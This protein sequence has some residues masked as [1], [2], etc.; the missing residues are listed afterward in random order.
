MPL[1]KIV[2]LAVAVLLLSLAGVQAGGDKLT[3]SS[4]SKEA[5]SYLEQAYAKIDNAQNNLAR[6][7]VAK[8][9]QADSNFAWAH[10]VAGS[11]AQSPGQGKKHLEKAMALAKNAS[12]GERLYIEA[13][14]A[15]RAGDNAK[16]VE[17]FTRLSKMVPGER[18]VF[19]NL[20][21]AEFELAHY[22]AALAALQTVGKME[23]NYIQAYNL[24]GNTY[25]IQGDYAAARKTYAEA[26][27][28]TP[29][30][31]GNLGSYFG[32]M[33]SFLYEG[34][35]DSALATLD[36]GLADFKVRSP[37]EVPVF[38]WN[39]KARVNLE[40]GRYDEAMKC[41]EQGY[42]LIPGSNLSPD[43]K[44]LWL[45]RMHHGV[46]RTLAHQ[47]KFEAAWAHA[48]TIKMMIEANGEKGA[49]YWPSYHYIAGYLKLESG[50]PAGAV[51]HLKQ[52]QDNYFDKFLMAR[53]YEGAG[54]KDK[55][56]ELL[57]EIVN[58][59]NTS[60]ERALIYKAAKA[61]LD[62]YSAK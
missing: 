5:R 33:N 17:M 41:Y 40:N 19:F 16:A 36:R 58:R 20:A 50:D 49:A 59:P 12:D 42:S 53:A 27:R 60:F 52:A 23:P 38:V 10:Y 37:Q 47:G 9:L 7:L 26:L 3:M 30:D 55:A 18:R 13:N 22:D 43:D 28:R 11:I 24:R 46:G 32:I 25:L 62:M 39:R 31:R 14:A 57:D 1:R 35:I 29:A 15:S 48:D 45:G 2:A 21:Q 56:R 4:K 34:Q 8:A 51:E 54:E 44:M 61:K 6:E